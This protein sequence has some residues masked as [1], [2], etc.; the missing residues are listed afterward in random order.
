M[1]IVDGE[2]LAS[3]CVIAEVNI[4]YMISLSVIKFTRKILFLNSFPEV[5]RFKTS[6]IDQLPSG[7][8]G[9]AES[10]RSKLI[11]AKADLLSANPK[12]SSFDTIASLHLPWIEENTELCRAQAMARSANKQAQI[13]WLGPAEA[14][15]ESQAFDDTIWWYRFS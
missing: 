13:C 10:I 2:F 12:Y 1:T 4:P 15:R 11:G 3:Y 5:D 9:I 14:N 6:T 7:A 8:R